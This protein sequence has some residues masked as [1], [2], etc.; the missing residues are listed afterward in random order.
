MSNKF[1][2]ILLLVIAISGGIFIFYKNK[3]NNFKTS[4]TIENSQ[5]NNQ[6]SNV[7]QPEITI[8]KNNTISRNSGL[9]T[10]EVTKPV[11]NSTVN[12]GS[13]T[14]EG[15]T[16]AGTTVD[17]NDTEIKADANG[18]FSTSISLDE[19]EN[20]IDVVASDQFGNSAEKEIIINYVIV[21]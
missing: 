6:A 9:I 3:P 21:E 15:K 8:V 16:I 17:V 12:N 19:G 11:N 10:L 7:S 5:K 1:L 4:I 2:F 20:I 14:V 18:L 13:I